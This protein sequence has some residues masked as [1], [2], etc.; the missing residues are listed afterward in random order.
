MKIFTRLI[1]R[2][3]G[4]LLN[5][6]KLN[7]FALVFSLSFFYF[8]IANLFLTIPHNIW[9]HTENT[10]GLGTQCGNCSRLAISGACDPNSGILELGLSFDQIAQHPSWLRYMTG[11]SQLFS[12]RSLG[13]P[14]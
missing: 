7:L 2:E 5:R 10:E 13:V 12:N 11:S 9:N 6:A 1:A 14:A 8:R 4:T 3:R